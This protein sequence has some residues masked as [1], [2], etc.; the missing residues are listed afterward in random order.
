MASMML[1]ES[2]SLR[3]KKIQSN[4]QVSPSKNHLH[5]TME[6]TAGFQNLYIMA[7]PQ[8]HYRLMLLESTKVKWGEGY[9]STLD[10]TPGWSKW[11]MALGL[12]RAQSL[13]HKGFRSQPRWIWCTFVSAS[14]RL[15]FSRQLFTSSAYLQRP[16]MQL[17]RICERYGKCGYQILTNSMNDCTMKVNRG[18]NSRKPVLSSD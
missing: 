6:T 17:W 3:T 18:E 5:I 2:L 10:F 15:K 12:G 7:E 11:R 4:D 13:Q 14:I 9:F 8:K 16:G 1:R